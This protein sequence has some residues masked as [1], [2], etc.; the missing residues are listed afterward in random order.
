MPT[1]LV[2]H[3]GDTLALYGVGNDNGWLTLDGASLSKCSCKLVKV[4]S[5]S[6]INNVEFERFELLVNWFWCVDLIKRAIK[7]QVIVVNN[8]RKVIKLVV[9]SKHGSLPDLTFFNLAVAQE[10]VDAVVLV[11]LLAG[12]RHANSGGNALA[13]GTGAHIN[14]RRVVHVWMT[15]KAR[16][17]RAESLKLLLGEETALSQNAVERWGNVTL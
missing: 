10:C 16:V 7:L 9:T 5:I 15:L 11:E 12:Q 17:E 2:L 14:A 4:V 3:E 8:K 6:Y 13:Q 1:Y